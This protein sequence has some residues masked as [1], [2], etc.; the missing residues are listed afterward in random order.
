LLE[1]LIIIDIR[2]FNIKV[3]KIKVDILSL[4]YI[5]N[6]SKKHKKLK[7]IFSKEQTYLILQIKKS[8]LD[9]LYYDKILVNIN[10]YTPSPSTTAI[11]IGLFN[12][13]NLYFSNKVMQLNKDIVFYLNTNAEFVKKVNNIDIKIKVRFT[14]FDMVFA[15]IISF[16]KRGKYVKQMSRKKL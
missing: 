16:Y 6:E 11:I 13:L 7:L 3:I 4:T 9:K 5:I 12:I 10:L 1:P 15:L 14:I 2:V 8:I